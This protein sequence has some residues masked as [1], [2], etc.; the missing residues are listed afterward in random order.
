VLCYTWLPALKRILISIVLAFAFLPFSP[1]STKGDE[2][3]FWGT[4]LQNDAATYLV[5]LDDGRFLDA[6]WNSGYDDWSPG[7]RVIMTTDE[8][9]GYMGSLRNQRTLRQFAGLPAC[10]Q[11]ALLFSF[12]ALTP[13]FHNATLMVESILAKFRIGSYLRWLGGAV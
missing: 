11:A 9:E 12:L 4:V 7:D 3:G 5:R 6:E 1:T 2:G 8:G 13:I 10:R